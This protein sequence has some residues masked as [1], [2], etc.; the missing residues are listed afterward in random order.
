M[1]R[2]SPDL[3]GRFV[4]AQALVDHLA[5][6]IVVGPG[7]EFD[8]DDQLGP[9][10]MDAAQDQGR[11]ETIGARRWYFQWHVR[12]GERLQNAPEPLQFRLIDTAADAAGM[13]QPSV[14]L[15]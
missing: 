12:R 9:S 4:L 1:R 10:P 8:L 3:C 2:R 13:D 6:Q 7:Q 5:Q 14:G 15:K 11:S